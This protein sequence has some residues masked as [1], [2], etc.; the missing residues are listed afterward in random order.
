MLV[1]GDR[2]DL[3]IQDKNGNLYTL[4][5]NQ[6]IP[7]VFISPPEIENKDEA[8]AVLTQVLGVKKDILLTKF[9]RTESLFELVKKRI[10]S[11]EEER[12]RKAKIP[13][14]YI[15][16]ENVRSY[17]QATLASHIIGFTNIEENG[18]YGIEEYYNEPLTGK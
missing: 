15:G 7:F 16:Q 1:K 11:K 18:Q 8:I 17:P 13:G 14:V 2:G 10:T 3:F 9:Q 12:I 6:K 4:A 5:A